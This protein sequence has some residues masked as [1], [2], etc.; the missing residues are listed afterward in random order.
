[1]V[2]PVLA[3]PDLADP[4]NVTQARFELH[5]AIDFGDDSRLAAW[6]RKWGE[7]ALTISDEAAGSS[8]DDGHPYGDGVDPTPIRGALEEAQTAIDLLKA[9]AA[10]AAIDL[11]AINRHVATI[12]ARVE[13]AMAAA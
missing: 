13:E 1:M 7:A 6:A 5:R 3:P 2:A 4:L 8:E 12:E 9:A 10:P 11:S